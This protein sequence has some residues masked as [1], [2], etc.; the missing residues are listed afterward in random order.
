[1]DLKQMNKV[2]HNV[3][4]ELGN[5]LIS[6]DVWNVSDAASLAGYNSQ[7][8]A[9]ALFNQITG[10]INEALE[11][12]KYPKLDKYYILD[13]QD[14][15]MVLVIPFAEFIWEMLIDTKKAK[16]G[17]LLNS[18]IPGIINSFEKLMVE[19]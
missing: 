16:L 9:C 19:V 7:P 3:E 11:Q 5:A 1:M 15:K 18:T 12:G 14:D 8:V 6:T 2:L 17:I 13:L 4:R 10:Y